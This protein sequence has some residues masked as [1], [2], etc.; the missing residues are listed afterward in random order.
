MAAKSP[1]RQPLSAERVIEGAVGLADQ[2]GVDALTIRK[3][4][5]ALDTKPMTIYHHVANKDAIIDGMV[6]QVYG[7]IDLPLTDTDWRT[8][9]THRARSARAV[10][11]RHPWATPL[12]DSREAP[13]PNTLRHLNAVLGCF[14]SNGFSLRMTAHAIALVDAF[15]FGYALQEAGLPAT[16][17]EEAVDMAEAMNAQMPADLY[18]Y[19]IEISVD[20]VMV[21]GYDFGEEFDFGLELILDGLEARLG[22]S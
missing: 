18:P 8:A 3:L 4:A 1:A 16:E 22:S 9:I 17:G 12:M 11:A 21:P 13:G 5:D 7:E 2:I 14:R 6:D 19:L 20:H 15:I 10:L